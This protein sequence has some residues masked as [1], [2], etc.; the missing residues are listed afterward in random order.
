[1][2]EAG[3]ANR[4]GI[5]GPG[6]RGQHRDAAR[7]SRSK[8]RLDVDEVGEGFQSRI[9]ACFRHPW[10]RFGFAREHRGP[11]RRRL[12]RGQ[13]LGEIVK[14]CARDSRVIRHAAAGPQGG[15]HPIGAAQSVKHLGIASDEYNA[16]GQGD[17]FAAGAIWKTGAIPGFQGRSQ[18]TSHVW[19]QPDSRREVFRQ[20]APGADA[21]TGVALTARQHA[22]QKTRPP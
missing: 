14:E 4:R 9:E 11:G 1:M 6:R 7:M 20:L 10:V 21:L 5:S 12:G 3:A 19:R 15:F 22:R 16:G 2:D 8:G 18:S 13:H 17:V